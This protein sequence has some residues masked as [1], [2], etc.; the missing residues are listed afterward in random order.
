M[1]QRHLLEKSVRI[2]V[3]ANRAATAVSFIE[4]YGCFDPRTT[5]CCKSGSPD[6]SFISHSQTEGI[7]AI[8]MDD[9]MQ[10]G[11]C[12]SLISHYL[13]IACTK[14]I[15]FHHLLQLGHRQSNCFYTSVFG[16]CTH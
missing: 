5:V 9:G 15:K 13:D 10:V 1:L 8:I 6:R 16:I 4:K 11:K 3:G 7:G 12:F 2:G 14:C